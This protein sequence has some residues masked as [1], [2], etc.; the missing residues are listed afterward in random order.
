MKLL[1]IDTSEKVARWAGVTEEGVLDPVEVKAGRKHDTLVAPGVRAWL[2]HNGWEKPDAVAVVVGPGGFTGLRVGVAFATGLA[3]AYGV[4]VVPVSLYERL[5][6]MAPSGVVWAIAWGGRDDV[7]ARLMRG[8]DM[9]EPLSEVVSGPIGELMAPEGSEP[10]LPLGEGFERNRDTVEALLGGRLAGPGELR[11]PAL[12]LGIAARA[13][14]EAGRKSPPTEVDV[15][16][17][18]DFVPTPKKKSD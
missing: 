18:A 13:A 15:D 16:Y 4:P 11:S 10:L 17:G 8:G 3:A 9:P 6:A 2:E 12:A 7:R 5:A 1:A 14:W